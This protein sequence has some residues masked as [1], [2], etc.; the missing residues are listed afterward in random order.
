MDSVV[1]LDLRADPRPGR[2]GA[3]DHTCFADM[4]SR[5]PSSDSSNCKYRTAWGKENEPTERTCDPPYRWDSV[6]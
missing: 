5:K 3:K 2:L 4:L 1:L 6:F